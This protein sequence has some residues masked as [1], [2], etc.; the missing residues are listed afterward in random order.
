MQER[1]PKS[2]ATPTDGAFHTRK[3]IMSAAGGN[4][5]SRRGA[6]AGGHSNE[7][8]VIIKQLGKDLIVKMRFRDDILE[9][10]EAGIWQVWYWCWCDRREEEQ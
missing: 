8:P 6:G 2:A 1:G 9:L 7:E 5:S 3:S 4:T 10:G